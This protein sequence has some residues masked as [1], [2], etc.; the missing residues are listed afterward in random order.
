MKEN[1]RE[2]GF[3][4]APILHEIKRCH[5]DRKHKSYVAKVRCIFPYAVIFGDG[6]Y[7]VLA[8]CG[9][10]SVSLH[11]EPDKALSEY[12]GECGHVC[13]GEPKHDVFAVVL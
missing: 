8:K 12:H 4:P 7:A 13:M 6:P 3:V 5:C 11:T 10:W 2:A 1:I 9:K